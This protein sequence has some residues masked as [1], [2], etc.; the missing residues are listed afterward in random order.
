LLLLVTDAAAYMVKAA[1]VAINFLHIQWN[2][3]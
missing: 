2:E 1:E 3:L